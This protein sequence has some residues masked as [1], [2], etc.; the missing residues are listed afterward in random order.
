MI[1]FCIIVVFINDKVEDTAILRFC[2]GFFTIRFPIQGS[3]YSRFCIYNVQIP[4]IISIGIA[5]NIFHFC[6]C[7]R[8][9]CWP[10]HCSNT[11]NMRSSHRSATHIII[12]IFRLERKYLIICRVTISTRCINIYATIS[13]TRSCTIRIVASFSIFIN[14]SYYNN[15]VIYIWE[16][17]LFNGC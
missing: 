1:D 16:I 5:N 14:R 11:G 8:T 12:Y 2:S 15:S 17:R 6:T 10:N 7:Q 13:S 4:W 9:V 3:P